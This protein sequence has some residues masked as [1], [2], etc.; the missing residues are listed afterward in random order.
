MK[1]ITLIVLISLLPALLFAAGSS[2]SSSSKDVT[3]VTIWHS[4]QGQN[5]TV[6]EQIAENFNSSVGKE[7]GIEIEAIYQGKANDVLTKV[8]AASGTGELPDIAM[9]DATAATDMNHSS[10]LVNLHRKA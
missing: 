5:T 9:M 6:F 1:R 4:A 7:K 8:N 3:T 2:E 10:Y